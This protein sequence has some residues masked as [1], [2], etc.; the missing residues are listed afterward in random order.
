MELA[1]AFKALPETPER[2]VM[3]LA[4][5]AEES[6]LLGSK[7]YAENPAFP[8][9]KTVAGI[10]IDGMSTIGATD[11][12]V[13]VGF[14]NSQM[15]EYLKTVS[16]TQN[17]VLVPEPTPEK[18]YFYRSDHFNLAKKGVP[19]LYAEAG[20]QIRNKAADYGEKESER[21]VNERYH[22]P[23][24]EVHA[25]WDNGG[26]M[27]D[28]NAH[29]RIGVDISNSDAWPKWSDGNEFKAIREASQSSSSE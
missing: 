6:G 11:D 26:I 16:E 18:G 3:F 8:M 20:I 4:V 21:Y 13:V 28:L 25:E 5:T 12:I 10:N 2:S 27:Q 29:F 14:G 17:R 24:D 22:K 23:A 19:M 15:D 7:H 1:E 9:S